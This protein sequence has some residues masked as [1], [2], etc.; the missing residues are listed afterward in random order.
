MLQ[1]TIHGLPQLLEIT[2]ELGILHCQLGQ[3]IPAFLQLG[4][5]LF[6]GSDDIQHE[7]L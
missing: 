2:V 4:L 7:M 5:Q 3:G 6:R 1:L